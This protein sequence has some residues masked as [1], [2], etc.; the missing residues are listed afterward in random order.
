MQI[1]AK[2]KDLKGYIPTMQNK[3]KVEEKMAGLSGLL[4]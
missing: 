2:G 1:E 3:T 4:S